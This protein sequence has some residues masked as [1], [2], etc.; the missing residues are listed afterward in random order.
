MNKDPTTTNAKLV[1]DTIQKFKKEELFK[2]KNADG[3]KVSNPKTPK[4]YIQP[5]IH[6]KDNPGRPVVRSVNCFTASI[7]KD[8]GYHLQAIVQDMSSYVRD[9]KD[10]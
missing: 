2:E 9:A 3:L 8:V 10:F 4:F 7:S 5:K 1:N 6:N